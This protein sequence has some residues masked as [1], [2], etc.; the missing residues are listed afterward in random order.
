MTDEDQLERTLRRY[1]AAGP[2]ASLESRVLVAAGEEP[3]E[4]QQTLVLSPARHGPV[5]RRA[6]FP[7]AATALLVATVSF[8]IAAGR[9]TERASASMVFEPA[10]APTETD[11]LIDDALGAGSSAMLRRQRAMMS[12]VQ[13]RPPDAPGVPGA[14]DV[15]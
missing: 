2:P 8:L 6:L 9:L 12:E 4:R 7:L 13:P 3:V 10:P 5:W 1:R 11:R 14:E 15:R